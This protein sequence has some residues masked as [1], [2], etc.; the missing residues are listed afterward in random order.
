[1]LGLIV[2]A[3]A[4]RMVSLTADFIYDDLYTVE[5]R[6]SLSW[7]QLAGFFLHNQSAMFG[8]NFYRPVLNVIVQCV[9]LLAGQSAFGW[10][11]ASVLVHVVCV[12]LLYRL[13]RQ[14]TGDPVIAWLAAALFAVHPANVEAITWVSAMGDLL[15]AAFLLGAAVA[16]VRWAEGGNHAWWLLSFAAAIAAILTKEPGV[17]VAAL[18]AITAL[19]APGRRRSARLILLAGLPFWALIPPYLVIRNSVLHAAVAHVRSGISTAEMIYTWPSALLFYAGHLLWPTVAPYYPLQ[20]VASPSAAL[21]PLVGVVILLA[22]FVW[23]LW[24]FAGWR[25]LTVSLAWMFLPLAPVLYLKAFADFEY[26]HDR[27]LYAALAGFALAIAAIVF[28]AGRRLEA[29]F[30]L[31]LA[32]L[33][34]TAILILWSY[35]TIDNSFW[36]RNN[37]ALFTR[38]VQVTPGNPFALTNLAYGYIRLDRDDLAIEWLNRSLAIRPTAEA[39]YSLGHIAWRHND[40]MQAEHY[41]MEGLRRKSRADVWLLLAGAELRQN[42]LAEAEAAARSALAMDPEAYGA[43]QVL[44][45]VLLT[46]GE[47]QAAVAEFSEE[48]RCYPGNAQARRALELAN[49][50]SKQ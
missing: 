23:L 46:K 15:L 35:S 28:Y 16:F 42:K 14:V 38:A 44:G 26:V 30:P 19:A 47:R 48:L 6:A 50:G 27:F 13:A 25:I 4:T 29:Y 18:L 40:N 43:H 7:R 24:R 5:M 12:L 39:Y 36:W 1:M 8:S 10:H 3:A 11:L 34:A 9:F 45:V 37:V 2:L 31:R 21:L 41:L 20:P 33:V 17:T 49:S 32:P 22:L